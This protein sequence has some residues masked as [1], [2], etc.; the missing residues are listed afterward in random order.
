MM[1]SPRGR[2]SSTVSISS[3]AELSS[4][5]AGGSSQHPSPQRDRRRSVAAASSPFAVRRKSQFV[6]A[7]ESD[8]VKVMVRVRPFVQ[9][10][11]ALHE[12]AAQAAR[13]A[14]ADEQYLRSMVEM[15]IESPGVVVVLDHEQGWAERERYQFDQA[16]WSIPA[17]QQEYDGTVWDQEAVYR[18]V[19]APAHE[20]AWKGYNGCIF[21]YGQTGSGKTY[22]MMGGD[23][24]QDPGVIPRLC[25]DMFER[26]E[27]KRSSVLGEH[28]EH[29]FKV[30]VRFVEIYNE[31]VK[32]L[33]W[34]LRTAAEMQQAQDENHGQPPDPSNLK[35]RQHPVTGP[36]VVSLTSRECSSW[37]GPGGVAELL[38][39]GNRERAVASTAMNNRSSRSHAIFRIQF[40]QTVKSKPKNKFDKPTVNQMSACVNLVDLAGS[41]RVKK[42]KAE[43]QTLTEAASINLSLTTLKMVIDALVENSKGRKKA[44]P[45]RDAM[46]TW[47]LSDSLGGNSK[48]AM[49]ANVSPHPDNT[50]ET[51]N[52]L[53]YASKAREIINTVH[54]NEDTEAKR[55]Q[56]LELEMLALQQ[57]ID[58]KDPTSAGHINLR[59]KYETAERKLREKKAETDAL[60]LEAERLQESKRSAALRYAFE[61]TLERRLKERFKE[62]KTALE[63]EIQHVRQLLADQDHEQSALRADLAGS[64][65]EGRELTGELH[66]VQRE[67]GKLRSQTEHLGRTVDELERQLDY[68]RSERT[69]AVRDG[70]EQVGKQSELFEKERADLLAKHERSLEAVIRESAAQYDQ[71]TEGSQEQIGSLRKELQEARRDLASLES[72]SEE[73]ETASARELESRD[74]RIRS[75]VRAKEDLEREKVN[76]REALSRE[77][78]KAGDEWKAM[79]HK[80]ETELLE[81]LDTSNGLWEVKYQKQVKDFQEMQLKVAKQIQDARA[82]EQRKAD[83]QIQRE[84]KSWE[85]RWAE[86]EQDWQQRLDSKTALNQEMSSFL[87]DVESRERKYSSLAHRISAALEQAE[88]TGSPDYLELLGTLRTFHAEYTSF[89]PSK[90]KLQQLLR[91]DSVMMHRCE[92]APVVG[93][94]AVFPGLGIPG[95][96][97]FYTLGPAPARQGARPT[98]R[99]RARRGGRSPSGS[100]PGCTTPTRATPGTPRGSAA[101]ATPARSTPA[102]DR[103]AHTRSRGGYG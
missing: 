62:Q 25:Q 10:E 15:P 72:E 98:S 63:E 60:G 6:V 56:Q 80:R 64:Q 7:G 71:L 14:G 47:L 11:L 33:L 48:T 38:E 83:Y 73:R 78:S 46:L 32:D 35:V 90:Y 8:A 87:R 27:E 18:A 19:G 76:L 43:G 68:E 102:E 92:P 88:H 45:F 9:R 77:I 59:E 28:F 44:I 58:E 2:G 29:S 37:D 101:R 75:L 3:Q 31:K 66:K 97:G 17:G 13:R 81:D 93:D 36:Y 52:T 41:E 94:D 53:R 22:T 85:D 74:A 65:K 57:Q 67:V 42:S 82:D 49:I 91:S 96:S 4:E 70:H 34:S 20:N 21:A 69:R 103:F 51:V 55:I 39:R 84:Q 23:D 16:I 79:Y 40:V 95:G 5:R 54:V 30:E 89:A 12:T 86:R 50:E 26:M 1:W 24:G 61:L 100:R 99:G